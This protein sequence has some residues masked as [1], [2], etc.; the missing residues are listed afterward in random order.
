[1]SRTVSAYH[2]TAES[3]AVLA[4]EGQRIRARLAERRA[5][6]A[7]DEGRADLIPPLPTPEA[8][9]S[10]WGAFDDA[11]RGGAGE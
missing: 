3:R 11:T 1:M 6:R 4:A 7:S 8:T 9:E 5:Q 10:D 2:L